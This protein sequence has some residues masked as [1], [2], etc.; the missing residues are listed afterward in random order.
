MGI[1]TFIDSIAVQTALYWSWQRP[2]GYGGYTYSQP[3]EI[4]C[5]WDG[6]T[7][8]IVNKEGQTITSKAVVITN[9]IISDGGWLYLGTL[10]GLNPEERNNPLLLP[11]A[12]PVQIIQKTPLFKS[13][14]EFIQEIYL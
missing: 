6:K 1:L 2:D 5:R 13:S 14:T 11:T 3:F 8:R 10:S 12:Y 4:A 9:A 7:K